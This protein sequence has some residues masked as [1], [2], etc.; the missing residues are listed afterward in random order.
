MANRRKTRVPSITDG[1]FDKALAWGR[2]AADKYFA[3][4]GSNV[5]VHI[6]RTEL[7]VVLAAS[8]QA[9]KEGR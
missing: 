5:E 8:Y 7:S 6:D 2:Q 1:D 4:R 3:D 9:G